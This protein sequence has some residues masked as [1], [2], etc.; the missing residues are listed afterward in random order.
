[1]GDPP[2]VQQ[3]ETIH[4]AGEPLDIRAK[5]ARIYKNGLV[6]AVYLQNGTKPIAED[7]VWTAR[8]GFSSTQGRVENT[9]KIHTL[10]W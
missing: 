9:P 2:D 5:V 10:I 1:M 8:N 3:G 4:I 6:E 7:V